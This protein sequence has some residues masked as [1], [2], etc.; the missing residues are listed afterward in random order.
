V[1][2]E[3]QHRRIADSSPSDSEEYNTHPDT[4]A[5]KAAGQGV[6]RPDVGDLPAAF[7]RLALSPGT[8]DRQERVDEIL[9]DP[10]REGATK[11]P[12]SP[13]LLQHQLAKA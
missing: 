8:A 7:G 9:P 13:K 11:V 12:W 2:I 6:Y 5:N 10:R 3:P 1:P 4:P